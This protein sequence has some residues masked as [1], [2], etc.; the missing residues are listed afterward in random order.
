[1]D[2]RHITLFDLIGP[3][4]STAAAGRQI[5]QMVQ[6]LLNEGCSVKLDFHG[7]K[8]VTPSF[9]EAVVQDL[10][11]VFQE[12]DLNLRFSLMNLPISFPRHPDINPP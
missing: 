3:V 8:L 12:D 10:Y 7:V 9:Y 4:C 6:T 1:M 5:N 11:S 2:V